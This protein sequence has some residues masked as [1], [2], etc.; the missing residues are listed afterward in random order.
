[1]TMLTVL[2]CMVENLATHGGY[3][4]DKNNCCNVGGIYTCNSDTK[5]ANI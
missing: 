3:V 4:V 5:T 2:R 1:M